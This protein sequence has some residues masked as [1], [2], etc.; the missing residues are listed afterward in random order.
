MATECMLAT[1]ALTTIA[2]SVYIFTCVCIHSRPRHHNQ[3]SRTLTGKLEASGSE[4]KCTTRTISSNPRS[5]VH[6]MEYRM[7][8]IL[9]HSGGWTYSM[10]G[11]PLKPKVVV[12]T[13]VSMLPPLHFTAPC[14]RNISSLLSLASLP[15]ETHT[16]PSLSDL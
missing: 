16:S 14:P 9:S 4:V 5:S 1:M 2:I 10:A 11:G 13:C 12:F 15:P 8:M 7:A 6:R 3:A